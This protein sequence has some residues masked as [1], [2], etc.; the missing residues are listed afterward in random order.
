MIKFMLP[1]P[2]P[3]MHNDSE[4]LGK[5][6]ARLVSSNGEGIV[7]RLPSMA[8]S[9][10][11][12]VEQIFKMET[13]AD[14]TIVDD[15][16]GLTNHAAAASHFARHEEVQFKEITFLFKNGLTVNNKYFNGVDFEDEPSLE[17]RTHFRYVGLSTTAKDENGNELPFTA[18]FLFWLLVVNK[19]HK[20]VMKKSK[21]KAEDGSSAVQRMAK[22]RL[23]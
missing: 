4:H 15:M 21:K 16:S 3:R 9:M 20:A 2:D 5:V 11:H 18:P 17:L 6:T 1:I 22:C 13:S 14:E 10:S 23:A 12:G 7:I 19:K 8:T